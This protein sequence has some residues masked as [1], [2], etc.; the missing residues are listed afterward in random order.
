MRSTQIQ[1][2]PIDRHLSGFVLHEELEDE[3]FQKP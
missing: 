1:A 2:K 3:L